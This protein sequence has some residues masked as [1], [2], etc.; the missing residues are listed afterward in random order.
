MLKPRGRHFF[1]NPGPTNIPDSVLRALDR[2]SIDFNDQ[3]FVPV[4]D[5]AFAGVKRVLQTQQHL[6]M[7][8]ASGHGAW[9]ASLTNLLSPGDTI[10]VLESGYFSDEWAAMARGHG[11]EV[12][13][14]AADWRRGVD[15]ADV[16]RALAAD[17]AHAI[18]AV[19]VVH[20]ETATGLMLP[21]P[22]IRTAIDA[23][24][25]PALFLVDTISSL[26]SLE[27]R[28][29]AW[30]VDCVVGGSQK[31]LM[32]PTGLSF[33][34]VSEKAMAAHASAKLHRF[35]FDWTMMTN[36]TQKS[37][38][39]TIPVNVF[40][41]LREALRLLEEEGLDNVVARH[42]RLAEATRR[43]VQVWAGNNGPTLFCMSPDRYSNS[44][45]AV[46]MPEGFNGDA[47]RKA[48]RDRFNVSLGGGLGKLGGKIFRIGHLGDLNE[49][50]LLGALAAVEMGL[51]IEGIPHGRG[52]VEAA[53]DFLAEA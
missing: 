18:K 45:T 49:P 7:Y 4:Y 37:F 51:R 31:G 27:F 46:M 13:V 43:A 14:V 30:K 5:E 22:A 6:F 28:M 15:V 52:G 19:C 50:M 44:V 20:N 10:L 35:Y 41:G 42:T 29:D 1:A 21:L 40:Y 9:E 25:H 11:L 16:R 47:L 32:L 26:G 36:R 53:M 17:T 33:T 48:V 23:V 24:G 12:Q 2:P 38:I 3:E 34:A 39:G 8:N